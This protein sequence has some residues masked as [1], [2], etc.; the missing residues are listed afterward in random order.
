MLET[1]REY[2]WDQ[3]ERLGELA[4]A[5]RAHA[6]YFLA[7]AERANPLLRGRDQRAWFA[8]LER[9][10]DNL[11]AALR[12]LLDQDDLA[13]REAALRLAGALDRFWRLRGYHAEGVRWLEEALRRASATNLEA[14]LRTR[15]LLAAGVLITEQGEL[16]RARVR[17][18]AA[19]AEARQRQDAAA[20]AQ[21]LIQLGYRALMAGDWAE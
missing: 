15:A 14:A 19:L 12:W 11:R 16:D 1:V 21:A 17:L 3:L 20:L 5:R 2:A 18:E 10:H 8:R 13:E 7:L 6:H 4:A 9:E